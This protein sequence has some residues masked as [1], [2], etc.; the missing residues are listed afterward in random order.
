MA[1]DLDALARRMLADFD[2]RTPGESSA[3]PIELTTDQA[4]ALQTAV[5]RL[6]ADRGEKIIGYKVGCISTAIQAQLGVDGPIFGRLFETDD[7]PSG[8]I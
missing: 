5:A 6:R 2:A 8:V 7:W 3:G 1:L 4:Y